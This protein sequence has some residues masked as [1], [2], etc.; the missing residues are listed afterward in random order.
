MSPQ[1]PP[2]QEAPR[3]LSATKPKLEVIG[4]NTTFRRD[5]TELPVLRD[6]N[7]AVG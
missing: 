4:V 1:Q 7:L 2:V 6:I 5:G 3:T